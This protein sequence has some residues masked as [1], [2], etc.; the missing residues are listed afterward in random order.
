VEVVWDEPKRQA[1]LDTHGLDFAAARDRFPFEEAAI[2]PTYAGPDGRA[3]FVAIG[4]LEGRLVTIVF[5]QLGT[6]A[7]SLISM[8]PASRKERHAYDAQ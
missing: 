3:R 1:N 2:V 7:V 6:E 8:R 5:S 4:P